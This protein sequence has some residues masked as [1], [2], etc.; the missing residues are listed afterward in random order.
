MENNSKR[1]AIK[2]TIL[3]PVL[4]LAAAGAVGLLLLFLVYLIPTEPIAANVQRGSN[5]FTVEGSGLN[6][7]DEYK[8][9]VLDNETDPLMLN[10]TA[11]AGGSALQDA[12]NVPSVQS[13]NS[14]G[15]IWSLLGLL[16]DGTKDSTIANYGRYWHGY[17]VIMKPFF[18]LFSFSDFRVFN[19][20]CQMLLLLALLYSIST[21]QKTVK[22]ACFPLILTVIVWNP[23]TIGISLQY[24][25]CYYITLLVS[26][27]LVRRSA[28]LNVR[29]ER[30][31]YLFLAAGIL[32]SYFDF[33]TYPLVT[34]GVPFTL[35]LMEHSELDAVHRIR[36][37]ADYTLYWGIGYAV[38]WTEKWMYGTA[39][40]GSNF[41]ADGISNVLSRSSTTVAEWGEEKYSRWDAITSNIQSLC[42]WPYII[43]FLTAVIWI[44]HKNL[45]SHV[46]I[47]ITRSCLSESA[48]FLIL[49]CYPLFWYLFAANHSI[50]HTRYAYRELGIA[51][52]AAFSGLI[53]LRDRAT[54]GK[55]NS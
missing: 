7:T 2:Q 41:F 54:T 38:M 23:A 42:K 35:Y 16:N 5:V 6:Y 51:V 44:F 37:M 49:C 32:T 8:S 29:P 36:K 39:L 11:Y 17:L 22:D 15:Q 55:I 9:T 10:E 46:P 53:V 33:L 34:F 12:L 47:R 13:L 48:V 26:L 25:A 4:I 52:M 21:K 24:S 43:L 19:Q 18:Y 50:V 30:Y 31:R 3:F 45:F 40:T 14:V 27:F 20:I 1:A 28:F